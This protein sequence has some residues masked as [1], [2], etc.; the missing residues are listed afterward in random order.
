MSSK[1][2]RKK[3]N[4]LV[5]TIGDR[6]GVTSMKVAEKMNADRSLV[7]RIV[8][9]AA[10]RTY[11]KIRRHECRPKLEQRQNLKRECGKNKGRNTHFEPHRRRD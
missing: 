7:G 2:A 8:R 10:F 5:K 4:Q 6:K 1:D 3:R 11:K 9:E